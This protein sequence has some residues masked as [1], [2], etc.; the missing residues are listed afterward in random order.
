M[1]LI[2]VSVCHDP[3]LDFELLGWFSL[4]C[5]CLDILQ[6]HVIRNLTKVAAGC[7]LRAMT[8]DSLD[9]V[10]GGPLLLF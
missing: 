6:T 4:V 10:G 7:I 1:P 5:G 2:L 3:L 9:S 8:T